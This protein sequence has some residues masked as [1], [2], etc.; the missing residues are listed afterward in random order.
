M[1]PL[2]SNEMACGLF[3]NQILFFDRTSNFDVNN[4][5]REFVH[6]EDK[7]VQMQKVTSMSS[8]LAF[9]GKSR[10]K[11]TMIDYSGTAIQLDYD[12]VICTGSQTYEFSQIPGTPLT[13]IGCDDGKVHK[14]DIRTGV[15]K[16]FQQSLGGNVA[17]TFFKN[18]RFGI[19]I[20]IYNSI[21]TKVDLWDMK[22]EVPCHG[23]CN[24]CDW[25]SSMN[26]CTSCVSPKYLRSDG[27]CGGSCL[28]T[29]YFS[30][31]GVCS[32]CDATCRACDGG[33]SNNCLSCSSPLLLRT[34]KTCSSTCASDEFSLDQMKCQKCSATCTTCN[35]ASDS[36]CTSCPSGKSLQKGY[37]VLQS[38]YS[39]TVTK[40]GGI[41]SWMAKYY[42]RIRLSSTEINLGY[43]QLQELAENNHFSIKTN[44]LENTGR[45]SYNNKTLVLQESGRV[46]SVSSNSIEFLVYKP[47]QVPPKNGVEFNLEI[48]TIN[49][50][51]ESSGF[52]TESGPARPLIFIDPTLK[53][54]K[55]VIPR[56][57]GSQTIKHTFHTT[58]NNSVDIAKTVGTSSSVI[59]SVF[60]GK[61]TLDSGEVFPECGGMN[62]HRA[63]QLKLRR[64]DRDRS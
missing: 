19:S 46:S 3:N 11:L 47:P 55:V 41:D 9:I 64:V 10:D 48:N 28:D 30:S 7:I 27:S 18:W 35:S 17:V 44:S 20:G 45:A 22:A 58:L 8:K 26:G 59:S 38:G 1:D 13:L 63:G 61:L 25:I 15:S 39:V 36:G 42:L 34:D 50:V 21:D 6:T 12:K 14:V 53:Q 31:P 23:N 57:N 49:P 43:K 2:L 52:G 32:R 29:D 16:G 5:L 51:F 24:S 56:L 60:F 40:E 54:Q 33:S 62:Q 37:C 4:K